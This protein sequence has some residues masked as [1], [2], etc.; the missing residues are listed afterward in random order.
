M[1]NYYRNMTRGFKPDGRGAYRLKIKVVIRYQARLAV[2]ARD[3]FDI[4][5]RPR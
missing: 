2:I 4:G 1:A 5:E 3:T